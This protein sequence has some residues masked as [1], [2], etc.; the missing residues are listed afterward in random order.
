MVEQQRKERHK[1]RGNLKQRQLDDINAELN[2][3]ITIEQ[4]NDFSLL[5]P[6]KKPSREK[7]PIFLTR[8]EKEEWER[9]Q[10]A[11]GE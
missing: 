8:A 2:P 6:V 9:K 7:Q 10:I 4:T 5:T 11:V 1:R 3:V